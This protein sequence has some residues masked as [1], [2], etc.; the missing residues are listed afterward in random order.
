MANQPVSGCVK[1][2]PH[3]C[4]RGHARI[5]PSMSR[6]SQRGTPANNGGMGQPSSNKGGAIM[7]SKKCCVMCAASNHEANASMGDCNAIHNAIGVRMHALPMNPGAVL[8]GLG[9]I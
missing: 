7:V 5:G 4:A 3:C 1:N 6:L 2:I 8:H 9:V